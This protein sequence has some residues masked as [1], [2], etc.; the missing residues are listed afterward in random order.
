MNLVSLEYFQ[1]NKTQN[2]DLNALL[3]EKIETI[4]F[5]MISYSL[6]TLRKYYT[7][8]KAYYL[9]QNSLSLK[10]I[11]GVNTTFISIHL[12]NV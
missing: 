8:V 1:T 7:I 11:N 3:S 5:A 6:D 2:M 4:F 10:T 9:I 12:N